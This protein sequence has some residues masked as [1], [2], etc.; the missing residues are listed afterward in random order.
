MLRPSGIS[1]FVCT[2]HVASLGLAA[3]SASPG[4]RG[5]FLRLPQAPADALPSRRRLQ[6]STYVTLIFS[7]NP[8][9][10]K[11]L[12][13]NLSSSLLYCT[14]QNVF[15]KNLGRSHT[16]ARLQKEGGAE[17]IPNEKTVF[18]P[19][20]VQ[21][22]TL[23]EGQTTGFDTTWLVENTASVPVVV[24]YVHPDDGLEYSAM[25]SK[26][27]PPQADPAAILQPGEWKSVFSVW[28]GHV[29]HVRELLEDGTP[30]NILL[31]HRVG[32]L[33]I[34]AN[35]VM[36][37]DASDP[38]PPPNNTNFQRS[39]SVADR[40]CNMIDFGFRNEVGCPLHLYFVD[41]N[42]TEHFKFHL[43]LNA[44]AADFQNGWDS[45]YKFE[46][47]FVGHSFVARLPSGLFVDQVTI[48]ATKIAD[49]PNLKQQ[50]N[51]VSVPPLATAIVDTIG[52]VSNHTMMGSYVTSMTRPRLQRVSNVTMS[53]F[54][55]GTL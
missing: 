49:C 42:C 14:E 40:P 37:C 31:Q 24:A 30:G 11:E 48:E 16:V 46:S 22:L 1:K 33:P 8:G 20:Q 2:Q 34:R 47:T 7:A 27:S 51:T 52:Q 19:T 50:V 45:R 55:A 13:T 29:F 35:D 5:G 36:S 26:I 28:Q 18:C 15:K 23:Q 38:P 41:S 10:H 3:E 6:S 53:A 43:G 21:P 17:G 25:N 12:L 9:I 39:P 32:L 4:G 44:H 54:S